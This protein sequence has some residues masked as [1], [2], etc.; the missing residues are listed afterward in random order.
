MSNTRVTVRNARLSFPQLFEPKAFGE[1]QAPKYSVMLLIPKDDE[2]TVTALR[3]AEKEAA[4]VGASKFGGK[5][6]AKLSSVIRDG[7]VA[8]DTYDPSAWPERAGHY[9]MTVSARQQ[10]R[11]GVVDRKVQPVI[12]QSEVYSGVFANVTVNAYA[13]N[14]ENMKKGI[15]FGLGNVQVLGHGEPLVSRRSAEDD[16]E[17]VEGDDSVI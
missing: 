14:Y 7:D 13:Y 16:F 4:T 3:S 1:N 8:T 10:D 15:S 6:P 9:F 11:P 5:I 17:A 2:A 12:D